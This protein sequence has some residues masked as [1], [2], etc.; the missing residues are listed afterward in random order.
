MF[1]SLALE[2]KKA[3]YQNLAASIACGNGYK[4]VE[5]EKD[6]IGGRGSFLKISQSS[7][8]NL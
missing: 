5:E 4:D 7:R 1:L 2:L 6:S 3:A 8:M